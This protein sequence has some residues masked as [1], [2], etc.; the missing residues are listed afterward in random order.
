LPDYKA[1]CHF[2]ETLPLQYR[3][4]KAAIEG[5]IRQVLVAGTCLEYGMQSGG[6]SEDLATRPVT[7]Y[8]LAKDTLRAFLQAFQR[9]APFTLQWAR[10]FYMYGPG[11]HP[12]SLLEQLARA[13][14]RGDECFHMSGGEQLRDYLPVHEVAA[15]LVAVLEQRDWSAIVNISSGSPISVR[16]LVEEYLIR[17]ERTIRLQLGYHPYPDYEPMAFWGSTKRFRERIPTVPG[18]SC[19]EDAVDRRCQ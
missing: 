14:E 12:T 3:F 7:A 15:R 8:A 18:R 1:L 2:E 4:L 19:P 17:H 13:L 9:V 6:L 5:G 16:R 11:Q 10:L